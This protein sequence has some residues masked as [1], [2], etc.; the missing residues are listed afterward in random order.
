[1]GELHKRNSVMLN[2][3]PPH[4]THPASRQELGSIFNQS[5]SSLLVLPL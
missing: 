2:S 3:K 1:M 4:T 5:Q